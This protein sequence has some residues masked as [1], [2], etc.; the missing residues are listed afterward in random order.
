MPR[1]PWVS[2]EL[3][4]SLWLVFTQS[5]QPQGE[6][7]CAA[8]MQASDHLG[9]GVFREKE[10]HA[11]KGIPVALSD[12]LQHPLQGRVSVLECG[13]WREESQAVRRVFQLTAA[14]KMA[15]LMVPPLDTGWG[16]AWVLVAGALY[17]CILGLLAQAHT[18]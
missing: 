8:E 17:S 3:S 6:A 10:P 13:R 5:R 9:R 14:E 12:P 15:C 4:C 2:V 11:V 18:P 16:T 1:G 7:C